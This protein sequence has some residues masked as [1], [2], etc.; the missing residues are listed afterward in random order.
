MRGGEPPDSQANAQDAWPG[1]HLQESGALV[2]GA[3]TWDFSAESRWMWNLAS[4]LC[5]RPFQLLLEKSWPV[6]PGGAMVPLSWATLL[7]NLFWVVLSLPS[8]REMPLKPTVL[9]S[10]GL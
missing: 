3:T 7:L 4:L 1:H 9:S 2:T 6:C 8:C 5:H 10:Q